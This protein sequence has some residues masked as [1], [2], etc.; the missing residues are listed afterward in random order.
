MSYQLDKTII[1]LHVPRCGGTT[2]KT[3]FM[4]LFDEVYT[5]VTEQTVKIVRKT[6]PDVKYLTMEELVAKPKDFLRKIQVLQGHMYYGIH[7]IFPQECEYISIFRSPIGRTVS[8][9]NYAL[10]QDSLRKDLEKYNLME[11]R[12]F[13]Q[14]AYSYPNNITCFLQDG[15]TQSLDDNISRE[16]FNKGQTEEGIRIARKHLQNFRFVG[17]QEFYWDTLYLLFREF[18]W[19]FLPIAFHENK[20]TQGLLHYNP[21]TLG[22]ITEL[23]LNRNG[24]DL[25]LFN[26][27]I[28]KWK[29]FRIDKEERANW[30]Q[31]VIEYTQERIK[32][33]KSKPLIIKPGRK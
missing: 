33:A 2:L 12:D 6:N 23:I 19:K 4:N 26:D 10:S 32:L 5:L 24:N 16:I 9:Y 28:A 21:D 7:K 31:R 14:N 22:D 8:Y 29:K 30:I 20:S 1:F 17:L 18:N 25:M 15:G 3:I 27:V 11:L 13:A